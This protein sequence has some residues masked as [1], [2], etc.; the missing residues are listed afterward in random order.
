LDDYLALEEELAEDFRK[1]VEAERGV[2]GFLTKAFRTL[3]HI[4]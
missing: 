4:V 3:K 1:Y 2:T